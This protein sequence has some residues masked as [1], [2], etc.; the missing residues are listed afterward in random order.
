MVILQIE[1]VKHVIAL[2]ILVLLQVTPHAQ[3]ALLLCFYIME[4]A[5]VVLLVPIKILT[6]I[7]ALIAI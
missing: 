3:D 5:L 7:L 4:C 6:T 2:V 1:L